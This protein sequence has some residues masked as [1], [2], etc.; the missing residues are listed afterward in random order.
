MLASHGRTEPFRSIRPRQTTFEF[1]Y[2]VVLLV[3]STTTRSGKDVATFSRRSIEHA[4]CKL[5]PIHDH[6]AL[7]GTRET[8]KC[9]TCTVWRSCAQVILLAH[10]CKLIDGSKV[11]Q[12]F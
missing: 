3:I 8:Q 7:P 4:R 11:G 12:D 10:L 5:V 6:H 1:R 9:H 2:R